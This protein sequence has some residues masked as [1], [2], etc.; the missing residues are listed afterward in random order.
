MI[1]N[2]SSDSDSD[3][4][5]VEP[6]TGAGQQPFLLRNGR[7]V[8][9]IMAINP[10]HT[11]AAGSNP[12][13]HQPHNWPPTHRVD[14]SPLVRLQW[15]SPG[16]RL[17]AAQSATPGGRAVAVPP[18]RLILPI[19]A[20]QRLLFS[21]HLSQRYGRQ[22]VSPRAYE[23]SCRCVRCVPPAAHASAV[24]SENSAPPSSSPV[25]ENWT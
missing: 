24:A 2:D 16:P 1:V 11:T 25:E 4:E 22:V 5:D 17:G 3:V 14:G 13:P 23:H 21:L 9:S 6:E 19:S 20:R 10:R 7:L 18:I 8:P 12:P 15:R